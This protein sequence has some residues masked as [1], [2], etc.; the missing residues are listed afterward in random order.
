MT[1][2]IALIRETR[3]FSLPR[4]PHFSSRTVEH[5]HNQ[6]LRAFVRVARTGGAQ[7]FDFF[8]RQ[9]GLGDFGDSLRQ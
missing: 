8:Q 4:V 9:D 1:V 7:I 5:L 3:P 2:R 6:A